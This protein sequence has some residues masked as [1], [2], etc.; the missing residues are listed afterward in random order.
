MYKIFLPLATCAFAVEKIAR[1][2]ITAKKIIC[3]IKVLPP[4]KFFTE[5]STF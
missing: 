2:K 5:K 4:Q 1:Q 3:L